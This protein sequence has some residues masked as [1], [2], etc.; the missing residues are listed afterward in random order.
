MRAVPSGAAY[1]VIRRERTNTLRELLGGVRFRV[2]AI[3]SG[4]VFRKFL[5]FLMRSIPKP[6]LLTA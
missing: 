2:G 4:P 3:S 5:K 6:R 1:V